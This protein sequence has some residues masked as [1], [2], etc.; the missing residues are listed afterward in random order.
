[1]QNIKGQ[2][3]QNGCNLSKKF[4]EEEL[5]SMEDVFSFLFRLTYKDGYTNTVRR[6]A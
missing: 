2:K 6:E 1:M 3:C 5:L 4:N